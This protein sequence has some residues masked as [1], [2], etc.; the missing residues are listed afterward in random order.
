[1]KFLKYVGAELEESQDDYSDD[2]VK[3]LQKSVEKI[4]FDREMGRRYML[5]EELMKDE[6]NAGKAEGIELGKAAAAQSI[7]EGVLSEKA[8]ISDNLKERISSVKELEEIMQLTI[9]ATKVETVEAFEKELEKM[10][11]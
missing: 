3:R 7:L 8:P 10:G 5:F 6:Y 9:K 1:M 2:F 4:K 11:Y